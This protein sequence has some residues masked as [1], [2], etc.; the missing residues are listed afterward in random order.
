MFVDYSKVFVQSGNGGKGCVAFR[1]EKFVPKGG[2]SGGDGGWGGDVIV[3]V[4]HNL[5]TLQDIKYRKSYKA[6]H[7]EPGQGGLKSG[8]EGESVTIPVPKGT[9]IRDEA[10]NAI[11]ADLVEDQQEVIIARGGRGG[12]G[13]AHFAT[14]T[15]QTPRYADPGMP[16]EKKNL[17]F[18][19]KLFSDVG[20][21]GLPN[22][23]KSTLISKISAAR[24]KIADYP[25]TT[26]TPNLG[27][28]KFGN[29][30]SFLVADIPGLIEGA[31][32]GKGLGFR[33]LRH[34][35]R[36]KVLAFMI[37]ATDPSPEATY[38]ILNDELTQYLSGFENK[39]RFIIITKADL[40]SQ[41]PPVNIG[42]YP[43]IAL[44]AV[45]GDGLEKFIQT[46]VRLVAE[47]G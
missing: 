37:E 29:Y 13:N 4:D 20:L 39:P 36:T 8:S 34:L 47:N 6:Q 21:V 9:I 24:P 2:P 1:R 32:Y 31:H 7:G 26:L 35:E 45:T 25:F 33:F 30:K 42:N 43:V 22:A 5:N 12:R 27:I 38:Q 23:G 28:V 18:E 46:A 41:I 40:V 16:G 17:I 10:T 11:L 15:K 14:P 19:L 44:S 3:K